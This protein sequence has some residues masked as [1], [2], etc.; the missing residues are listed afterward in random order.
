MTSRG[1]AAGGDDFHNRQRPQGQQRPEREV[2]QGDATP[3]P[4]QPPPRAEAPQRPRSIYTERHP[5]KS[6]EI[7]RNHN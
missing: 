7:R 4:Q 2:G 6:N 1:A 3:Q 5:K